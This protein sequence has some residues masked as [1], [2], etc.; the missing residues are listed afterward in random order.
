MLN[1]EKEYMK[2]AHYCDYITFKMIW[3]WACRR[4]PKKSRR[5]IKLKYFKTLKEKKWSFCVVKFSNELNYHNP[6]AQC[7]YLCLPL[8]CDYM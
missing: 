4:H 5:W 8:H 2:G 3:K 1:K 6:S 7:V